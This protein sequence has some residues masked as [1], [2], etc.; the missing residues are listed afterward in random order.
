[1]RDHSTASRKRREAAKASGGRPLNMILNQ[2]GETDLQT[3][4]AAKD[5]NITEAIHMALRRAA[6]R[7]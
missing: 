4:M 3:I 6:M 5:L 2:D 7:L 1:M